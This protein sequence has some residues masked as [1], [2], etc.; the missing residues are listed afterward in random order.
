MNN[1]VELFLKD[2]NKLMEKCCRFCCMSIGREFQLKAINELMELEQ[3]TTSLKNDMI[4]IEDEDSANLLL[5]V[6][7]AIIALIREFKMWTALKDDDPNTAWDMLIDAQ[8]T[9]RISI[10]LHKRIEDLNLINYIN[11]L[12]LLEKLLFPPQSFTSVSYIF[13]NS[14]CSI[15][16]KE[17]GECEHIKGK[18][19]MGKMC[20]QIIKNIR[21]FD[22]I[23]MVEHPEDKHCRLTGHNNNG[24][25]RDWMTYRVIDA[26][27][28]S[29]K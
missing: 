13:E 12:Y 4:K 26:E 10:G 14:E 20:Q 16:G 24:V 25:I 11:R 7:F 6:E 15:C 29:K 1:D 22:H 3:K 27:K 23:A 21:S 17:Y 8:Q 2:F 5:G 28:D 19:Y 9:A 18:A